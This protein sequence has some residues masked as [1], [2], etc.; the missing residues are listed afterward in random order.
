MLII[1]CS[2]LFKLILKVSIYRDPAVLPYDHNIVKL[3]QPIRDCKYINASRISSPCLRQ[4]TGTL[5]RTS[6]AKSKIPF[7]AS[8]I[9]SQGP[10]PNTCV[11]HLQ[12]ILEQD[13]DIVIMLT[14][15]DEPIHEGYNKT[16]LFT[17]IINVI[18]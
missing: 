17:M 13:I 9:I 1:I 5:S 15:L 2:L 4:R 12:M 3:K 8:F 10:L 6:L 16:I 7:N 18:K 11:H 14:K